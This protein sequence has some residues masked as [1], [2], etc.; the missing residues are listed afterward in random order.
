MDY[1]IYCRNVSPSNLPCSMFLQEMRTRA[2]WESSDIKQID[3]DIDRTY[4]DHVMFRERYR[5]VDHH[6]T[7]TFY[8]SFIYSYMYMCVC[9]CTRGFQFAGSFSQYWQKNH[10]IL[11]DRSAKQSLNRNLMYFR[12]VDMLYNCPWNIK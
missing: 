11:L 6:L 4:R 2:H 1:V 5:W 8:C 12:Y 10:E 3:V 9:S 7:I